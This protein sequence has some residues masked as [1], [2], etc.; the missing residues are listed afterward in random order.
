MNIA[1]A[2]DFSVESHFAVRWA[3]DLRAQAR[4]RQQ[5]IRLLAF[6]VPSPTEE[7]DFQ[8][9]SYPRT[10]DDPDIHHRLTRRVRSF[11]ESVHHDIEDVEIVVQEGETADILSTLCR[12]EDVDWLIL[13]KTSTGPISRLFLGSTVHELIE[14][15]PTRTV[16]VHP[17]HARLGEDLQIAVGID[18]LPGSLAALFAAADLADLTGAELQ[19]IHALP[20]APTGKSQGGLVN[21]LA[22]SDLVHLTT[23]ARQSMESMMAE[24]TRRYPTLRYTILVH[25]GT[26]R[27]VLR[28]FVE[29]QQTDAL[30]VGHIHQTRLERWALGAVGRY[31]IRKMPTTLI[32]VPPP[33]GETHL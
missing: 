23:D 6:C 14:E 2:I 10:T 13:G 18:F 20:D 3:L 29:S 16:V 12:R 28:K 19:L 32:V 30:V 33:A 26:P 15:I 9:L 21:Y 27:M 5:P 17:D 7:F 11:L 31:L 8:T 4:E 25:S 22:P 24:L 1:V